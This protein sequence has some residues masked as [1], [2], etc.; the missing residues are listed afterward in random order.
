MRKIENANN[1]IVEKTSKKKPSFKSVPKVN[2]VSHFIKTYH[3]QNADIQMI[4]LIKSPNFDIICDEEQ[5][6]FGEVF[7][8]K[9]QGKGVLIRNNYLFEGTW[10]NNQKAK[11]YE[12]WELGIYQ[13]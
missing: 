2:E 12:S 13:G 7:D 3:P 10:M 4:E 5:L 9:M 6:Y 8:S 11:G 1:S